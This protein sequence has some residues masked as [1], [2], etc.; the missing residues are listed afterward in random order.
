MSILQYI[1]F[2]FSLDIFLNL[3]SSTCHILDSTATNQE[4]VINGD[5]NTIGGNLLLKLKRS[6]ILMF[7]NTPK[8]TF[9]LMPL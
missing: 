2:S 5:N 7:V 8:T 1:S 9:T 6:M 3:N 4:R